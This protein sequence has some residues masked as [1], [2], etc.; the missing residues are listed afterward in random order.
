LQTTSTSKANSFG[1]A[2]ERRKKCSLFFFQNKK[3]IITPPLKFL[4][5]TAVIHA[6]AAAEI[7]SVLVSVR[8]DN[9]WQGSEIH[10]IRF[11]ARR[12]LHCRGRETKL[13]RLGR[14]ITVF[15]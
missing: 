8:K 12:L 6:K 11:Q 2:F 5:D 4:F 7:L 15:K 1:N 10:G 13:F 14:M 3:F 9:L